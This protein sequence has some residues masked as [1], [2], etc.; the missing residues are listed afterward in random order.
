MTLILNGVTG[1]FAVT[2]FGVILGYF[3]FASKEENASRY[4]VKRYAY[5]AISGLFI[6]SVYAIFGILEMPGGTYSIGEVI[7]ESITIGSSIYATYWCMRDFF[8]ASIIS[9]LN[10]KAR[11]SW[12][13]VVIEIIIFYYLGNVWISICLLGCLVFIITKGEENNIKFLNKRIVRILGWVIVFVCIKRAESTFTYMVQGGVSALIILLIMNGQIIKKFLNRKHVAALGKNAMAIYLIHPI[14]YVNFG[15]IIFEKL[16][17]L[18][19]IWQFIGAWIGCFVIISILAMPVAKMLNS[20]TN[21][22]F[23]EKNRLLW[24]DVVIRCKKYLKSK[25]LTG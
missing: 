19:Y 25:K 20:L 1:K 24:S 17:K 2:L 10:S 23:V 16:Y 7:I 14:C 8:I 13:G 9:Y 12:G 18:P 22:L 6:N 11:V 3:A 21:Y 15:T 4:I 5:F